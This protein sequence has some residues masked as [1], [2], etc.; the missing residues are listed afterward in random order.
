MK[1][2]RII[3]IKTGYKPTAKSSSSLVK[4]N[5]FLKVL[6]PNTFYPFYSH[7]QFIDN[8]IIKYNPESDIDIYKLNGHSDISITINAIVGSNGSGKSTLIELIYWANY[9]IG[10]YLNL[11]KGKGNKSLVP[12]GF[13][14]LELVYTVDN[15][16]F[17]KL[18]F[19]NSF[20]Y[21]NTSKISEYN[22][23]VFNPDNNRLLTIDDL[24]EFFYSI[25]VN[26]SHYALNSTEIGEWINSLFHKN[27]GYQTPI[28]LNPMRK[29]GNIDINREKG[30]LTKRLQ[31]NLLEKIEQGN[32]INSLR[33]VANN[34]I[35]ESIQL[36][37][38]NYLSIKEKENE[39]NKYDDEFF[40]RRNMTNVSIQP[41][42]EESDIIIALNKYFD[43]ELSFEKIKDN[44]FL[45]YSFEYI[46]YKLYKICRKY[47][48]FNK[49][50]TK[51]EESKNIKYIDAYI[52]KIKDSNSHIVFKIKGIILYIKYFDSIFEKQPLTSETNPFN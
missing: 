11:I 38:F 46:Q 12:F 43:L 9:N 44:A 4:D 21:I 48:Q 18:I 23:V 6:S 51:P 31:A 45:K 50:K 33:N 26:Y 27:D 24:P 16:S 25:V 19:T 47:R 29:E 41:N 13:L 37:L 3:A 20:V 1:G 30:L 49:F 52:K 39:L 5:D 32:D 15:N 40:N 35:A 22:E 8:N 36:T 7:Y 42:R 14:D 17:F 28:V 10:C 34:K 2:F